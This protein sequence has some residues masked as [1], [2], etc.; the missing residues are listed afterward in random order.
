VTHHADDIGA[1]ADR[2]YRLEGG[3]LAL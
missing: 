1:I 3:R 2:V